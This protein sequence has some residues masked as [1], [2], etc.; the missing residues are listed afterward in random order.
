[1]Q[2]YEKDSSAQNVLR[3]NDSSAQNVL[4]RNDSSAQN[5]ETKKAAIF[6]SSVKYGGSFF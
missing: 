6:D 3:Q 5:V 2:I 4:G 1:V